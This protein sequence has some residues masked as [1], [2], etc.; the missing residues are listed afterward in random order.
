MVIKPL[1]L[2]LNFE[3]KSFDSVLH[4]IDSLHFLKLRLFVLKMATLRPKNS[5]PLLTFTH[6]IK[7]GVKLTHPLLPY[8]SGNIKIWLPLRLLN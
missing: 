7:G 3:I 2:K 4:F 6:A 5:H 1:R 8:F